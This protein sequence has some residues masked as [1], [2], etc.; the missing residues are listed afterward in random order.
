M[1]RAAQ[2]FVVLL[3]SVSIA[4]PVLAQSVPPELVN[5]PDTIVHNMPTSWF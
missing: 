4:G 5:Y 1:K 3:I 2:V